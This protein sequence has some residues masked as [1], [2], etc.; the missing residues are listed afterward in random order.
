VKSTTATDDRHQYC[1]DQ[2]QNRSFVLSECLPTKTMLIAP[3][4]GGKAETNEMRQNAASVR[5]T[6]LTMSVSNRNRVEAGRRCE[7]GQ[8]Q[9][10]HGY[11]ECPLQCPDGPFYFGLGAIF[12]VFSLQA[13]DQAPL[14]RSIQ[15]A[16][17]AGF[18]GRMK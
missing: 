11:I 4:S 8:T 10:D 9:G 6:S 18:S 17:R 7:K 12:G 1:S 13:R 14:F 3:A 16:N 15:P 5:S 2:V